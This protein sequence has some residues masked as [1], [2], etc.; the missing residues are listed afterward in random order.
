MREVLHPADGQPS[1]LD[2]DNFCAVINNQ[3]IPLTK[4]EW[5]IVTYLAQRAD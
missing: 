4:L 3:S 5:G 2:Y 1:D